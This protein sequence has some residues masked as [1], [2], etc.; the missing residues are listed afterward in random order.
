M[1]GEN[2]RNPEEKQIFFTKRAVS[3]ARPARAAPKGSALWT[4][5]PARAAPKGSALWTPGPARRAAGL[6]PCTPRLRGGRR[7]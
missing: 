7:G 2:G 3:L 4:P 1:Q 6:R 5:G